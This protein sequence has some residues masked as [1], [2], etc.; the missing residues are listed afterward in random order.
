MKVR[1]KAKFFFDNG[2]VKRVVWTIS[3]PTVIYGSPSKPVKTVLTTVKDV[4]DE[5]Q[6]SFRKLHKEGEVFTVAGIGGDLSGVHFNKVSYW[7]LKVEEIGE[8]EDKS[9]HVLA[10]MK[11]EI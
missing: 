5:F 4:Q 9:N 10:P 8:E 3:D 7:T 11:D 6:K 2:E 1:L